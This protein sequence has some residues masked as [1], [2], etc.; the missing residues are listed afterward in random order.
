MKTLKF[1]FFIIGISLASHAF[2]QNVYMTKTGKKY[3][4]ET[5]HYL[6]SSMR[7][8][9]LERAIELGYDACSVCKP[10]SNNSKAKTNSITSDNQIKSTSIKS[11]STQCIG[12]TKAG[13]RCKHRTNNSNGRCYQHQS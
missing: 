6:K 5:C 3:H 1:L 4:K 9:T 13:N 2:S 12:K 10:N 11:T 7:E 8:L